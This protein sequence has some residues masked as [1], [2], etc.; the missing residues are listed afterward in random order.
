MNL[1]TKI[2]AKLTKEVLP[3]SREDI[4]NLRLEM[5]IQEKL[6]YSYE[7]TTE[8]S[9]IIAKELYPKIKEQMVTEENILK[10]KDMLNQGVTEEIIKKVF[11]K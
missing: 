8:I 3:H 9:K 4:I 7:L 1:I 10:V 2:K 5:I 11:N 6:L